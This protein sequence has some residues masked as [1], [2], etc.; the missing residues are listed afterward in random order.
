M[1]TQNGNTEVKK[2]NNP[3]KDTEEYNEQSQHL[4]HSVHNKLI[5][6]KF[7]TF[8]VSTIIVIQLH[9]QRTNQ[10]IIQVNIIQP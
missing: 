10:Y 1:S 5:I 7:D 8:V 2:K 9:L 3:K 4:H 6:Y